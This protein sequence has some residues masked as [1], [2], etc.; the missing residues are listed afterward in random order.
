MDLENVKKWTFNPMVVGSN[1]T[2][3][4]LACIDPGLVLL[5]LH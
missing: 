5:K 1:P 3:Q 4:I 2:R